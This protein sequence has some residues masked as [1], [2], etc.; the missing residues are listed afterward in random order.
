MRSHHAFLLLAATVAASL[1]SSASLPSKEKFQI[2]VL[3]GQSNM[4]GRGFPT[5]ADK[6]AHPRVLMLNRQGEWVPCVDPIHYDVSGSGVGP[7]KA[8]A[9]ALAESDPT[10]TVGVVPCAV[11]GCPIAVW[12]P[13]K[14][15]FKGKNNW[16]PYDDCVA[17]VKRATQDGTLAAILWHQG[18]SDCM[19][20]CGYLYQARFPVLIHRLRAEIG[21]EGVPLVV[22]QLAQKNA[23]GWFG[24]I[25][26][27]TQRYTCEYLYGPGAFVKSLDTYELN[28]DQIHFTRDAQVDFGKRYF[29]AYKDV[30]EKLAADPEYWKKETPPKGL[31]RAYP[32]P[33]EQLPE[34]SRV[35]LTPEIERYIF[36][37]G[38]PEEMKKARDAVDP[39][40]IKPAEGWKNPATSWV[41]DTLPSLK[42]AT[43]EKLSLNGYWAFGVEKE[44]AIISN[45]PAIA[46]LPYFFKVPGKWPSGGKGAKDGCGVWDAQGR[47]HFGV[48]VES[49]HAA[50]YARPVEIP[51]SWKGRRILLTFNAIPSAV[52]VFVDGRKAGEAFFPG[53]EVDL[54]AHLT[55]G[56]HEIALFTS[57]KL[58]ETLVTAF[59][60]PDTART[61][62]KK[63]IENRGIFGDVA[64]TAEPIGMRISDV[65]VRPSVGHKSE[66]FGS[67]DKSRIDFSVGLTGG[68]DANILSA[69]AVVKKGGQVVKRFS[70]NA[71]QPGEDGRIVFGG[72]WED[73]ELWDLDAPQNLYTVE[74]S[75]STGGGILDELYP[76]TF[77]FREIRIDG[78]NLLLNNTP[79]HLRP[80]NSVYAA[81]GAVSYADCREAMRR[82]RAFGFNAIV[83]H[84]HIYGY[85][86]G[87]TAMLDM[88]VRAASDEGLACIVCLPHPNRFDNP[89]NPHHW[90]YGPA[91]ERIV[92][93][94]VRRM[95]NVP[96]VILWSSTHNQTGYESDQNPAL[97]TGRPEDVPMGIVN[98]RQRFRSL[99]LKANEI[100]GAID[101]TRPLYHHE[102]GAEGTFYTL[103]CYLDWAPIQ[104]RSDW[105]EHW[106]TNGVMPLILVEWGLPHQ[107]SWS[108][109]RGGP[110]SVNIWSARDWTQQCWMNEYNAA[111]L[112][113]KAFNDSPQKRLLMERSELLVKGNRK[114]YYGGNFTDPLLN[115][116]D[117]HT[118]LSLY[119]SRNL[120]DMRARGVTSILPWDIEYECFTNNPAL[121]SGRRLR[122]NAFA[123]DI[124]D[125]GTVRS[126][127]A[128]GLFDQADSLPRGVALAMHDAWADQLG[129]IAGPIGDFTTVNDTYRKGET[130]KKSLVL[131]N[132][133]RRPRTVEWRWQAAGGVRS[134]SA[135]IP[136]GGRTDVPIVFTIPPSAP[137]DTLEI[138]ASFKCDGWSSADSFTLRL[139]PPAG[140]SG[141][142]A[143]RP[144]V[145]LYDPEG[146]TK[147]LLTAMGIPF[148]DASMGNIAWP[149]NRLL[150]LGRRSLAKPLPDPI[151][152]AVRSGPTL[153]LEQDTATL[154][155]LGFRVQEHG[156]RNLF[157]LIPANTPDLV[158]LD[159]T[160]WRGRS[161]LLPEMLDE[162]RNKADF[163]RWDWDGHKN[164][165]VWRAGN[166]GVVASVLP[167]KP[168]IGNFRPLV[169]G[170]FDLQYAPVMEYTGFGHCIVF[171]QLDICGRT[172]RS[173]E[174]EEALAALIRIASGPISGFS[175]RKIKVLEDEAG[176]AAAVLGALRFQFEKIASASD[177]KPGDIL[178]IGPGTKVG[179]LEEAIAGGLNVLALG[180]SADEANA[181]FPGLGAKA[182]GKHEYPVMREGGLSHSMFL[183][184]SE[185]DLQWLFQSQLEGLAR[186]DDYPIKRRAIRNGHIVFS[187]I[188]PWVY[189]ENEIALRHHRRRAFA[190]VTRLLCNLGTVPDDG[191]L[192]HGGG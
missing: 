157:A 167:E 121:P 169:H 26:S 127:Y 151:V 140:G 61:F 42:T 33:T 63:S 53:G 39:A 191:F 55:P 104:E 45:A 65:Q 155:R 64:L 160:D 133:T 59:D 14:S 95:Q 110:K 72:E 147:P 68:L 144:L 148:T 66:C 118:V 182:C 98:W 90:T 175:Q 3:A 62:T 150:I 23:T 86:E 143:P 41:S 189:D 137:G 116:P 4:A 166:R 44:S 49:V 112:G 171:S 126:D 91:Y 99:A 69:A 71:V 168:A 9:E 70:A 113:E 153:V 183:G 20:R 122:P 190:L 54:T 141:G 78:R 176:K 117:Y 37:D 11:G 12:E 123:D 188:V 135:S 51:A 48:D 170:G 156:L 24:K 88:A 100:V 97:I 50:W 174:A 38:V 19:R 185:A 120:R 158:H 184:V 136:P 180:L 162:D 102:S 187:S 67:L 108:S 181:I 27:N 77:G 130:V 52:L 111:F 106:E 10:I 115:E 35:P 46:K 107:A 94:L 18:E 73:P 124:R 105:F 8:F 75:L 58:P 21:A 92:R 154:R 164:T 161:T 56:K 142:P 177:A 5:E 31:D 17:R 103:N 134:C 28:P 1:T 47:D 79:I 84:K 22:G 81:E 34:L 125:F 163:P 82:H 74:V 192:D 76:E 2:V 172:E 83:F 128:Y 15:F 165:R 139:L 93:H 87:D 40:K 43:R 7:G 119:T 13:G 101:P 16:H 149:M 80:R 138:S 146:T 173:P 32:I 85:S 109:F 60:A 159:L 145:F 129:W 29:E 131:L 186:F 178:V 36:P 57:A 25:I 96:G 114:V 6:V 30:R 152:N 179:S 89:K 132:D